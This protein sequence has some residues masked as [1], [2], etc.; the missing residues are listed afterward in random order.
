MRK[1]TWFVFGVCLFFPPPAAFSKPI[2][3]YAEP[4][5]SGKECRSDWPVRIYVLDEKGGTAE[6]FVGAHGV[7]IGVPEKKE[8]IRIEAEFKKGI[9]GI[10]LPRTGAK[11]I[12]LT[13]AVEGVANGTTLNFSCEEPA[14]NE[15]RDKKPPLVLEV[16]TEKSDVLI[17]RFSEEVEEETSQNT[18]NYLAVTSKRSIHPKAIEYHKIYV[19]LTFPEQFDNDEEGYIETKGI[20]DL[21]GNEMPSA[22]RSP[23]FTGDCN[24]H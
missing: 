2:Q 5:M 9:S 10:T 17:V 20:Q 19:V 24:C 3:I 11:N 21:S 14:K 23:Q 8:Q 18:D 4:F 12:S 1:I 6:E 7:I 15:S 13:L 16:L 22:V